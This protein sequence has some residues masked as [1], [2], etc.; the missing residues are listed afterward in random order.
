MPVKVNR[1]ITATP[2]KITLL[3]P[4][5]LTRHLILQID[6]ITINIRLSIP[7]RQSITQ[8]TNPLNVYFY[9]IHYVFIGIPDII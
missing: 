2:I 6:H 7:L 8:I 3:M 1:L 5:H 4:R 9:E